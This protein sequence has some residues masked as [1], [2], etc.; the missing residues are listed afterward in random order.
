MRLLKIEATKSQEMFR[1]VAK[2]G[3]VEFIDGMFVGT[4]KLATS[5]LD[6][7]GATDEQREAANK[8]TQELT[9]FQNASKNLSSAFQGTETSFLKFIGNFLGTGVGSLN[10]TMNGL[11]EDIKKMGEGTQT[12]LYAAKEIVTTA[13]SMLRET[14]PITA[15]TYAALKLWAPLGPGGMGGG[16]FGK[17][18]KNVAKVG[19][20][21]V[22]VSTMA[23]GGNIA[24]QAD[25]TAGKALGVGSSAA[26][27]ALTGA[28]IGSVVPVVGTAVGAAIGGILGGVYGL[29]RAS[30]YDDMAAEKLGL[31]GKARG[32]VGTT[33]NLR[34]INDNLSTIHA[35][36]RVLTKAETDSYLSSQATGGDNTALMSMNTTFNAMNTKMTAVVNEMK[37][38]NKN[39]NTLVSIDTDI[40]RNTDKTQRRLANKSESIV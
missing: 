33:G 17:G 4:N 7:T 30:D 24:D 5:L 14:A 32:T 18:L 37:T 13:G 29:F 15:G 35:G 20:G 28:M 3:Q 27:G 1:D 26:G 23:M 31:N 34:E 36:E 38:F 12:A 21:A 22:G 10:D 6:T 2:T 39:V 8:L 25:S 19:G 9:E 11:A 16:G 40:A